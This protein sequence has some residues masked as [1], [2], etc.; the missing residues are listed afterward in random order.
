MLYYLFVIFDSQNAVFR[1]MQYIPVRAAAGAVVSFGTCLLLG[2]MV[3]GKLQDWKIGQ[4]VR[5]EHVADLHELHGKKTGTP[6]MGGVLIL[7]SITVSMLICGNLTNRLVWVATLTTLALGGIGFVD[8]YIKLVKKRSLGL[9]VAWKLAG[10]ITIGVL[11]GMYVLKHPPNPEYADKVNVPFL[12]DFF[13]HLGVF[14]IGLAVLVVV[15]SSNAVNLTDGLDGL[16]CGS[17]VMAAMAYT[18]IAYVVGHAI[19][20]KH[21]LL[22]PVSQAGELTVFLAALIGAT[23]GFLWFNAHPAQVFMGDTGSLALGGALGTIALLT[24]QELVLVLIGGLFVM[25]ALSVILQ[26]ASFRLR[27]KRIF[28]MSPLHHHFELA[29]WSETQVV[30]RFWIIAGIFALIGLL[31]LKIR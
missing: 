9:T 13:L 23:I 12:K 1:L 19:Y 25:E 22:V 6:T 3:I 15:G 21:L 8:D 30:T 10:Q 20:S 26:V 29:G 24:K 31:T 7:A 2:P 11:L 27:G 18:A 28:K 4:V 5:K 16:A 14:Y 17:V